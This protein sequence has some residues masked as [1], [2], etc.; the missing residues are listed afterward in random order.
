MKKDVMT[1]APRQPD[2]L[3]PFLSAAQP[4]N[5]L[6][7]EQGRKIQARVL[8]TLVGNPSSRFRWRWSTALAAI[9]LVLFGGVA[10]AAAARYGLLPWVR[11]ER[12]GETEKAGFSAHDRSRARKP[13]VVAPTVA[14]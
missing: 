13:Q 2:G 14:P 9:G 1:S 6:T 11:V 10:A 3:A 8:E 7:S 5:R 4:L 12:N